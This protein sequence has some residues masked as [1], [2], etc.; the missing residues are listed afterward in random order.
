L[1]ACEKSLKIPKGKLKDRQ[2]NGKKKKDKKD[3]QRSTKH[4]HKTKDPVTRIPL[5]NLFAM[6]Q[7]EDLA[8]LL[9]YSL[10][11]VHMHN[12]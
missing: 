7:T 2:H 4:T 3:E 12:S 10:Y 5:I 9:L 11:L 6:L 8:T 1:L